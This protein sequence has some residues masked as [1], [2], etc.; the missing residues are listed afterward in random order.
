MNSYE[1]DPDQVQK[2]LLMTAEQFAS[3][4]LVVKIYSELLKSEVFLISDPALAKE[5]E[6]V[7]YTPEEI[8]VLA[9]IRYTL[10][11]HYRERLQKIHEAKKAF[12]GTL[13]PREMD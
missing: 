9:K 1:P 8:E 13:L 10:K 12:D 2:L 11:P 4:G 3:A 5:V 7:T 6:G